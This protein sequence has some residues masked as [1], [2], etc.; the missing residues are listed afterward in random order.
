MKLHGPICSILL[1]LGFANLTL[2]AQDTA[3]EPRVDFATYLSGSAGANIIASVLDSK[4][5][6]Y[7]V[8]NTN[9]ADFPTTTGAFRRTPRGTCTN[10]SCSLSTIFVT[11]LSSDGRSLVYSTFL[12]DLAPLDITVDAEGNAYLVGGLVDPGYTGTAGAWRTKC[13][14]KSTATTN[15][16]CSWI[17]KLNASGSAVIYSTLIDDV[18]QC[19]INFD[20]R[21]AVNA[22]E[23]LYVAGTGVAFSSPATGDKCFTTPNAYRRSVTGE[24]SGTVVMKFNAS[25]SG[26][27]FSTWVSGASPRDQFHGLALSPNDHAVIVGSAFNSNFPT[28]RSAFQRVGKGSTDVYV[29]KLSSDGSTLLASTLIGSADEDDGASVAVDSA[30]NVYVAGTTWSTDF[31]T[32]PG[33]YRRTLDMTNC[34]D[35][36]L[37]QCP[38][39]FV[40]KLPPDLSSLNFST[41]LG[42]NGEDFAPNLAIDKVGHVY[43]TGIAL[44]N[45]PLVKPLQTQFRP[46][47]VTKLNTSGSG[48]LFSTYFGETPSC[49]GAQFPAGIDVD[50][51]GNA[52]ISL[53]T[54]SKDFPTTE[55]AY[56]TF[57]HSGGAAGFVAKFDIPPC[58]LDNTVLS[59]TICT[60][61]SGTVAS[62]PVLIAAGASDDRAITG[63]VVY[64]D[65]VKKFTISHAS[66]FDARVSLGVGTHQLT[67]KAWDADGRVFSNA[68]MI[69]VH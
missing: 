61:V 65:G 21:L 51:A 29:A 2:I 26:V 12:N 64:V 13:L 46:L 4:R 40:A 34:G 67:V 54:D 38:D 35:P 31:P 62:S 52:Y 47:Y 27:L 3:R 63:M 50:D 66:H 41:Y 57:N 15:Q 37:Q 44:P 28:T 48:L 39:M 56:Q 55:N 32:T 43:L 59:V 69:N 23:E 42:G 22:A 18:R 7:V 49:C 5:N 60:P 10:G 19:F 16:F 8:G 45:H 20:Q 68:R 11:K 30:L 36:A 9:A 17:V 33:A 58:T 25:G 14:L 1:I 24:Q 53:T 6:L